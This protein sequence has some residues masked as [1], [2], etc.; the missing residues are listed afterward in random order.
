M[1]IESDISLSLTTLCVFHTLYRNWGRWNHNPSRVDQLVSR[2]NQLG[3]NVQLQHDPTETSWADH[4]FIRLLSEDGTVLDEYDSFQ[5]NRNYSN[6]ATQIEQIL[7]KINDAT[8]ALQ[9][10][11][12]AEQQ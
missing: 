1:N 12:P 10:E 9:D 3:Y 11:K 7:L 5:H 6:R 4:G 8:K 2:L